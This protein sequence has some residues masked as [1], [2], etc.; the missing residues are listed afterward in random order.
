MNRYRRFETLCAVSFVL[1]GYA[2]DGKAGE[3]L[4]TT[5][6]AAHDYFVAEV[7]INEVGPLR[8]LIDTGAG[9]SMLDNKWRTSLT[10]VTV[11]S[12]INMKNASGKTFRSSM[13]SLKAVRL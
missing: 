11:I 4:P 9:I 2:S 5:Y 8:L 7:H 6:L 13:V 1:F 12:Q 10:N 3:L